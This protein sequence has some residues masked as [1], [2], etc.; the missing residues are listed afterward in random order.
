MPVISATLEVYIGRLRFET[1]LNPG[2]NIGDL[3]KKKKN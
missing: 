3:I 2:K 1:A